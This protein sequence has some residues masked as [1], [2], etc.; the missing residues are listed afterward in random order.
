[1]KC[2]AA[3]DMNWNIGNHN[4]L[5][6]HL[7]QDMQHFRE[8]TMGQ[9]VLMGRKTFES[10]EKALPGRENIV[11][12][13][14]P[15]YHAE[16]VTIIHNLSEIDTHDDGIWC[17]GGESL[18]K[19]LLPLC[20]EVHLTKIFAEKK[21]DAAFPNLDKDPLRLLFPYHTQSSVMTEQGISFL[22][23]T[24]YNYHNSYL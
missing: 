6:F 7:K 13:S 12:T 9:T 4:E 18:Y 16:G 1:M 24:Y 20:T 11:L 5:L 22:F 23:V 10:I 14:D 21:A 15:N 2:I 3:V 8:L 17:I 19:Q